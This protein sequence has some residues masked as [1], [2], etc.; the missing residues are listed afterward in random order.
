MKDTSRETRRSHLG[1][2]L[3]SSS[4][5]APSRTMLSPVSYPG[6]FSPLSSSHLDESERT[7]GKGDRSSRWSRRD[8]TV[9]INLSPFL[10]PRIAR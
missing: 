8:A 2:H 3:T 4:T 7:L 1:N 10:R 6:H 9:P 5:A